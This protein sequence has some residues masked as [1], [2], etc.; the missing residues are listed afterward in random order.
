MIYDILI[1]FNYSW[2]DTAVIL[3]RTQSIDCRGHLQVSM[4][5]PPHSQTKYVISV[6][7]LGTDI[8]IER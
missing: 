2:D 5:A 6:T 1:I 3:N 4:L 8:V 7:G